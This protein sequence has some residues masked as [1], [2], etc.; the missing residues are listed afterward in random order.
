MV[1]IVVSSV[2][3][4]IAIIAICMYVFPK[5]GVWAAERSGEAQL[6]EAQYEEQIAIAEATARLK[7]A[8]M[9]KQAEVIEA[10]AVAE[11][12]KTIG[13]GINENPDYLRYLWI[14]NM[15]DTKDQLIYIPTEAGL[16]ILE[17]GRVNTKEA[18]KT[19]ANM[20]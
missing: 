9:N 5:Y 16:P 4:L 12:I 18:A 6:K 14:K 13:N 2:V 11:S 20:G 3:G 19:S 17:A 8:E 15:A 10:Q 1:G 7:A